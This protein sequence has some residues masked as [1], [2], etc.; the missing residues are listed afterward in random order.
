MELIYYNDAGKEADVLF[1]AEAGKLQ[2]P[3]SGSDSLALYQSCMELT[4]QLTLTRM[5]LVDSYLKTQRD[6]TAIF[7]TRSHS[8]APGNAGF[9]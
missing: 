6:S 1:L 5:Q 8:D 2:A 7:L 4:E 9:A 3:L